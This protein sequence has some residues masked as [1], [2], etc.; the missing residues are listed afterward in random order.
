SSRKRASLSRS[1][2]LVSPFNEPAPEFFPQGAD[3]VQ[4]CHDLRVAAMAVAVVLLR[5]ADNGFHHIWKAPA[6]TATLRH[7]MV[8][9]RGH[10]QLPRILIK[11]RDDGRLDFL[12]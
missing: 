11:H 6:A 8:N 12:L 9:F 1:M 7:R 2:T 4:I 3:T 5:Y 10:D